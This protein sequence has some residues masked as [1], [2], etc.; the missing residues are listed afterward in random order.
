[1]QNLLRGGIKKQR[2]PSSLYNGFTDSTKKVNDA[3]GFTNQILL[4]GISAEQLI[5]SL[6]PMIREEVRL[7]FSEQEERLLSPA[8]TCKLFIPAITKATLTSWTDKGW[9]QEHRIGGRVFYLKSEVLAST[10]TLGKYKN[11]YGKALG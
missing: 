3:A 4:N 7:V 1:M 10:L 6:R 9:L 11:V 2:I 8:E 5:E